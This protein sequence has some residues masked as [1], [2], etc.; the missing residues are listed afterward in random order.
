MKLIPIRIL[1]TANSSILYSK[2]KIN[3]PDIGHLTSILSECFWPLLFRTNRISKRI[4]KLSENL[5]VLSIFTLNIKQFLW[6]YHIL[7]REEG[8]ST[9][10]YKPYRYVPP[11]RVGFLRC[12]GLKTGIHFVYFGL[13]TGMIFEGS[14]GCMNVFI[15]SIPNE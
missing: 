14:T 5:T 6:K 3:C 10:F 4:N 9:P 1:Y 11:H 12:F 13:K 2:E 7:P 8:G 15:V